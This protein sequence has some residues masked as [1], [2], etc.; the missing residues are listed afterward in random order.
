MAKKQIVDILAKLPKKRAAY[1]RNGGIYFLGDSTNLLTSKDFAVLKGK[2]NLI[3]TS[4]PYPLNNKKSY[5]NLTGKK[6]LD[7][8]T[9]LA[10]VFS[11]LLT[12]DG[13]I[14]IE[15]GNSWEPGRPVQSLLHLESLLG[16]VRHEDAGLRLI[17]Q[18]VCYNPSRL[19]SPAQWVTVNR[20][21]TVDSFT[22]VWWLAK[23]DFPKADNTKVLR[24]Y[25]KS[26]KKLL[27]RGSY[28]SGDRPSEHYISKTGFLND[29]GGSIAQNLFEL[30]SLDPEREVRLPNV[31]S[32]ANSASKDYFHRECKKRG[33]TP[34]PA[35]MPMGLASF[36]IEF[37]T[38]KGGLVLDPFAGSN[39]TGYAASVAERG[40]IGID[41]QDSYVQQ[42]LI[43]FDAPEGEVKGGSSA[44]ES[45][46]AQQ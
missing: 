11:D 41:A 36:F 14:V 18:F 43:R 3:L 10:P 8:F 29:R 33:I 22:H 42:S 39:T 20:I 15:I 31:F 16:F 1:E 21:R 44:R 12:E 38:D 25:S 7:W 37:L 23:S 46:I 35:R 27:Q 24:P 40:W 17:Q 4:P 45:A 5:G 28:N 2:V 9:S 6:Y 30:D 26:M 13:S 34:H 19:P 32:L